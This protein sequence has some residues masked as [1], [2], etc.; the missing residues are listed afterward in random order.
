M[1]KN[2]EI[3]DIASLCSAA[4]DCEEKAPCVSICKVQ[5]FWEGHK[6]SA[7]STANQCLFIRIVRWSIIVQKKIDWLQ[8]YS[9]Y[10]L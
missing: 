9:I 6:N 2:Q 7:L 8:K 3:Y 4:C 1:Q 10:N 5:I